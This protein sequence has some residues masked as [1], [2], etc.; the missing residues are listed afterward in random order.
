LH[1]VEIES[2]R[3]HR[4]PLEIAERELERIK[5]VTL[6]RCLTPS[7]SARNRHRFPRDTN[8]TTRSR[9]T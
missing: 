1:E 8:F 9:L 7:T 2:G 5:V 4:R 6:D 3:D